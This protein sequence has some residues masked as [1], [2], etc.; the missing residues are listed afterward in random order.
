MKLTEQKLIKM[1]RE[2]YTNR[3]LQLEVAAKIAE[4]QLLDQKGNVLVTQDLKVKHK[5]SGYEYTVDR[6]EGEGEEA[7]IYLRKPDVARF[8]P[9]AAS[10]QMNELDGE[11]T[12]LATPPVSLEKEEPEE[13]FPVTV[14]DFEK[15][16]IID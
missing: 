3:L 7:V 8:T 11:L 15:E 12:D 4:A 1:I 9:P 10:K 6:V 16:Y 2:E 14:S 5:E 13:V